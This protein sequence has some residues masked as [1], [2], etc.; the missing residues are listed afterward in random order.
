MKELNA[1]LLMEKFQHTSYNSVHRFIHSGISDALDGEEEA[2]ID[3][4]DDQLSDEQTY[5]DERENKIT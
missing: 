4:S 2:E 1:G 3:P 5:T